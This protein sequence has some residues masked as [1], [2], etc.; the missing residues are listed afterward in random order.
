MLS[1]LVRWSG[2]QAQ[3]APYDVQ[4]TQQ[5][6]LLSCTC[7]KKQFGKINAGFL[8]W[9]FDVQDADQRRLARVDKDWA[10]LAREVC[11]LSVYEVGIHSHV[12]E[13]AAANYHGAMTSD[14]VLRGNPAAVYGRQHLHG[15]DGY[16][17]GCGAGADLRRASCIVGHGV[18]NA[19][20]GVSCVLWM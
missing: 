18:T 11:A 16:A 14:F 4:V 5:A 1:I 9:D 13:F 2:N 20:L 17:G 8:S 15:E 3:H 19:S 12:Q 6:G 7:S 10:G